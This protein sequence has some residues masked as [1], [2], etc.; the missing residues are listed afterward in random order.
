M[1]KTKKYY[2]LMADI[3][4]SSQKKG[5]PL[6]HEFSEI[7]DSVKQRRQ[8]DFLSPPTITLGDEFQSVIKDLAAAV[9]VML[10]IEEEIIIKRK[11]F[12]LRYVLH[13]GEIETPINPEIAWGM[14]GT[15]LATARNLLEELKGRRAE[16]FFLLLE[17][18]EK[19][20]VL[21]KIFF[22]YSAVIDDWKT[23]D[24][25]TLSLFLQYPDY[26][27]VA[28][29]LQKD[30]SLLWRK[31][32]TLRLREYSTAKALVTLLGK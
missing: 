31:E 28:E 10:A 30:R 7:V 20:A 32:K 27:V 11:S 3:I 16:R 4:K 14:L 2:I 26:K 21:N 29:K 12:K 8:E 18:A 9:Q 5:A 17:D 25:E 6:M 22:L 1:A 23:K 19:D 13:Y 15:G 24:A